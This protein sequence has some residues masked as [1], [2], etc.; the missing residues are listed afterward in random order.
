MGGEIRL[1]FG[2][3][4]HLKVPLGPTDEPDLISSSLIVAV[5]VGTSKERSHHTLQETLNRTDV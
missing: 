4:F 2:V 1:L 3:L 5:G